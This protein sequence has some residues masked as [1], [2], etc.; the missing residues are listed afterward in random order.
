MPEPSEESRAGEPGDLP[1]CFVIMPISDHPD[2]PTGHFGEVYESI[3]SPA[4]TE[5]GYAPLRADQVAATNLIHLD[6]LRR[7]VEAPIAICDLSSANPNVMFE[8]GIRQA[9]DKPV[10]LIKDTKT[11][12]IFDIDSMRTIPYDDTMRPRAVRNT[13]A[14]LVQ[15]IEATQNAKP[16]DGLNSIVGLLGLH[17]A[18]LKQN[19]EDPTSARMSLLESHLSNIGLS[20]KQLN[21]DV[22]R[23]L[24]V[25]DQR[26][27][28]S[29]PD[30]Y[31][32][33]G[34][35]RRSISNEATN[36]LRGLQKTN[37][38]TPAASS[39]RVVVEAVKRP[40]PKK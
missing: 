37:S 33:T 30:Q 6:I 20:I 16:G 5:C 15:A 2:Y 31:E 9:F 34:I 22:S 28:A 10:V 39:G 1:S 23:V 14:S 7:I 8:L 13:V 25:N 35:V 24:S 29:Q 11:R 32:G 19:Q 38:F 26:S 4:A 36:Y 18:A 3:I 27:V 12:K 21:D 17:A 40:T